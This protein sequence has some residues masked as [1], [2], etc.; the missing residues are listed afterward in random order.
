[1]KVLNDRR[2]EKAETVQLTLRSPSTGTI[3]GAPNAAALTIR[4]ND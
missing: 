4:A 1:V 2:K 3:L